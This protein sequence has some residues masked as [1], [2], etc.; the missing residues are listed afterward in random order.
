MSQISPTAGGR[1]GITSSAPGAGLEPAART[2]YGDNIDLAGK[3]VLIAGA[4]IAFYL[5]AA[6]L[7]T[8]LVTSLRGPADYLPFEPGARW[9]LDN[10][11][12]IYEDPVLY[13]QILPDT[14]I[15][16]FGSVTLTFA[17]AFT[18]AWLVER[19][20]L[21]GRNVWFALILF[22]FLVPTTVLAI[23]WIFLLGP[24]AG[25]VNVWL[26]D[27]F[28]LT[29]NGPINIFSMTGLIICQALAAAPFVFVLLCAALKSMNPSFEEASGASGASPWTTFR[30]ITMP[31]LLP[32]VLAP[33]ILVLLITLEQFEIPLIIG[34]PARINVF[35]YRIWYELNPSSGL[36][37]YGGAAAVAIPFLV[38]GILLLI[39]YNRLIRRA[40]SF[41]TVTGKAYRQRRFPLG[42]W[43]L[44]ALLF[45]GLL[46]GHGSCIAGSHSLMDFV[47]RVRT[48]VAAVLR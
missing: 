24:Q 13:K 5:L 44:P 14:L 32:G 19:T 3:L 34:L 21:P 22:P 40:E 4:L 10:F 12:A 42:A 15:F 48:F 20:D 30:R 1:P 43:R 36:P 9:T 16:A 45:C 38:L 17:L 46:R 25:W 39:V 2:R 7:G 37:N 41:V 33:V 8:L 18:L 6:P 28:G 27:I 29:G 47:L 11:R 23:A 31:V 26:R 35:S